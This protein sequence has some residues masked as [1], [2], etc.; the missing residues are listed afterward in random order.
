MKKYLKI[1]N[2]FILVPFL[3]DCAGGF[4][5]LKEPELGKNLII[6]S[7]VFENNG[8]QN[9]NEVYYD[10]LEV[11]IIG[12]YK[13]NGK[14]KL[15]GK[16]I[17][18]DKNGY[19]SIANVPN[20]KYALKGIRVNLS[21]RAYLTIAN[22]FK[23][24]VDNY[25]IQPIENIA[26]S[27]THFNT[28]PSNQIINLKNN[29]FT[30]FQNREIRHGAYDKIQAFKSASSEMISRPLIFKHFIGSFENSGWVGYLK[31]ELAKFE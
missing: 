26:F 9:R 28:E 2:L 4:S 16:W 14:E 31:K 12:Y 1:I 17:Y 11:A 22:E 27:G 7:I 19:F 18:T 3:L 23:S 20:G 21:G 29:Y 13:E 5:G 24:G 6:G 25:Q 15:F 10:N 8:Y 30:I